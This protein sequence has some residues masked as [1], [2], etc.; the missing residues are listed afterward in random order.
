MCYAANAYY[1]ENIL[2]G[3]IRSFFGGLGAEAHIQELRI[4]IGQVQT[5]YKE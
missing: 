3:S 2:S 5:A 1:Q 4:K